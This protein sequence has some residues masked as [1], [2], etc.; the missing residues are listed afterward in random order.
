M[1]QFLI[2]RKMSSL[3]AILSGIDFK[4]KQ[5]VEKLKRT[6]RELAEVRQ[7]NQELLDIIETQKEQ[8]KTLEEQNKILILRNT[9]DNT[10]G[11]SAK[12]KLKINKLIRD[13]DKSI[14]LLTKMEHDG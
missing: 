13:I 12:V 2:Y 5:L 3:S 6:E 14:E 8:I 4:I 7:A 10:K 9:L 11:D 1:L